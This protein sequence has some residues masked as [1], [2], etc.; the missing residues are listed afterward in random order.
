[1]LG[2]TVDGVAEPSAELSEKGIQEGGDSPGLLE[3]VAA[4]LQLEREGAA[5]ERPSKQKDNQIE[6][7]EA[8]ALRLCVWN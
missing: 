5:G 6:D 7:S 2:G 8:R 1:M 3:E 4:S